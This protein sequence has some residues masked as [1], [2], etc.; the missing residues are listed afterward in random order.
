[1]QDLKMKR[2]CSMWVLPLLTREQIGHLTLTKENLKELQNLDYR[3]CKRVITVNELWIHHYNPKLKHE[4]V[5]WLKR[6]TKTSKS[7]AAEID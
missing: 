4:S 3:Y 7:W 2:V 6:G 1:M 5:T